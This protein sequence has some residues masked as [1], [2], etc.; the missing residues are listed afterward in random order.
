M[1]QVSKDFKDSEVQQKLSRSVRIIL[2][3]AWVNLGRRGGNCWGS[4][5]GIIER[6]QDKDMA[7]ESVGLVQL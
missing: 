4:E 3:M 1:G 2:K 7:L 6:K 5:S